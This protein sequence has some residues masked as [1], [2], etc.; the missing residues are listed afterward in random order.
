M[1][2][3]Y[4]KGLRRDIWEKANPSE[5]LE[6]LNELEGFM[7]SQDGRS[8]C[9]LEMSDIGRMRGQYDEKRESIEL[10]KF[11]I[12]DKRPYQA[13]ETLL[14][15]DRH[16]H[17]HHVV[18]NPELAESQEQLNDWTM[19]EIDNA[20]IQ[21]DELNY[22][23]YRWQPTETDAN[24]SARE[25]T[26]ALYENTFKDIENY[27]DYKAFKEL[28]TAEQVDYA[29]KE[30]GEN[31]EEEARQAVQSKYQAKM[32]MKSEKTEE[33]ETSFENT[34]EENLPSVDKSQTNEES[35]EFQA[36][37]DEQ[38]VTDAATMDE[39]S[40]QFF[41]E[42]E[43]GS[44]VETGENQLHQAD[45]ADNQQITGASETAESAQT[46]SSSSQEE[47]YYYGYGM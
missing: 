10:N 3:P 9:H 32:D 43:Q 30:L 38:L 36:S 23:T 47:D 15:E 46:E 37:P 44:D 5:K 20:Y 42:Q 2:M 17:Q 14:H 6:S 25:N 19:G 26:N 35:F 40:N 22:S 28:E 24:Q 21:P 34:P 11:L 8:P 41:E 18:K 45:E 1:N 4:I 29:K 7:A 27:P 13:V 16:A 39:E 31:Y 33:L 12:E